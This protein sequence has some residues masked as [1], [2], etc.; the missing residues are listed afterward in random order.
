MCGAHIMNIAIRCSI[1]VI[2]VRDIQR[3][4]WMDFIRIVWT[5]LF[6]F[7]LRR[8]FVCVLYS[9]QLVFLWKKRRKMVETHSIIICLYSSMI[10][11]F[12]CCS[13]CSCEIISLSLYYMF[14]L[15]SHFNHKF[16]IQTNDALGAWYNWIY[17][18][19]LIVL[20]SFFMLN[21]VL[22]VLSG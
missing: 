5:F 16:F 11:V 9:H 6:L 3:P 21:L 4:W 22:G 15:L 10:Y 17:F 19:P 14:H 18:V 7:V 20:G 2:F 12:S 8:W 13:L 1:C